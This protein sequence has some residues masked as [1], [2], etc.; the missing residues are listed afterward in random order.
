MVYNIRKE[1]QCERSTQMCIDEI[2]QTC[3]VTENKPD[4][5]ESI[6][7][8]KDTIRKIC[9]RR[10]RK[11]LCGDNMLDEMLERMNRELDTANRTAMKKYEMLYYMNEHAEEKHTVLYSTKGSVVETLLCGGSEEYDS[12]EFVMHVYEPPKPF[13]S[14]GETGVTC[15]CSDMFTN[16]SWILSERMDAIIRERGSYLGFTFFCDGVEW[17]PDDRVSE[18]A[19]INI[20][21]WGM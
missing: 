21:L 12:G 17:I 7:N 18:K 15:P 14:D 10:L 3:I 4:S 11:I 20:S 13:K 5:G 19:F 1:I 9:E 16:I 2:R 6:L 8:F